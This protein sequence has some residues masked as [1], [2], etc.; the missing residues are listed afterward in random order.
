MGLAI[1][2][3]DVKIKALTKTGTLYHTHCVS[4]GR[5]VICDAPWSPVVPQPGALP[6]PPPTS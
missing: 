5:A 1:Q 3:N 2:G 4:N 6:V